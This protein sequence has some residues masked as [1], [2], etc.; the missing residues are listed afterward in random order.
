MHFELA[1]TQDFQQP[2]VRSAGRNTLRQLGHRFDSRLGIGLRVLQISQLF[3]EPLL[4]QAHQQVVCSWVVLSE[5]S[6][7]RQEL[8]HDIDRCPETF[9]EFRGRP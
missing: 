5:L 1:S 7:L 6:A 3:R 4:Q 2:S 9:R 8:M